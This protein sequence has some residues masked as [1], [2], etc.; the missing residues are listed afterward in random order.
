MREK[1]K[2]IRDFI[3]KYKNS[4]FVR[5][6][7]IIFVIVM[8]LLTGIN[9]M[10]VFS[11]SKIGIAQNE[12]HN[13][14]M[15]STLKN[16]MENIMNNTDEIAYTLMMDSEVE[17]FTAMDWSE[18]DNKFKY[19][20]E[21][22]IKK[23]IGNYKNL[24]EYVKNII[25]FSGVNNQ[26]MAYSSVDEEIT[27]YYKNILKNKNAEFEQKKISD[28]YITVYYPINDNSFILIQLDKGVISRNLSISEE[29]G[30]EFYVVEKDG[31]VA[32]E[33]CNEECP[34]NIKSVEQK[35]KKIFKEKSGVNEWEYLYVYTNEQMVTDEISVMIIVFFMISLIISTGIAYFVAMKMYKPIL[36]IMNIFENP[37]GDARMNYLHKNKMFGEFEFIAENIINTFSTYDNIKDELEEKINQLNKHQMT[38]LQS[39]INPHFLF[40]TLEVINL[41]AM[42]LEGKNNEV[43]EMISDLSK[44]LRIGLESKE[45]LF[46][47]RNEIEYVKV[48]IGIMKL[49]YY[50]KFDV[51]INVENE[52]LNCKI[53][54]IVLQP[55]VENS[56][57][58]GIKTKSGTGTIDI[59]GR[60]NNELIEIEVSDN[61]LGMSDEHLLEVTDYMNS[62]EIVETESIGLQNVNRRIKLVFGEEYGLSIY[63]NESGGIGVKITI[64]YVK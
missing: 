35:N 12:N 20:N 24:N 27:E 13:N 4:I 11:Y 34:E 51:N 52:I 58:H 9:I 45:Q 54:K 46:T 49:R 62:E 57:S 59:T 47:I 25:I 22:Y 28:E 60:K 3:R 61:G 17:M 55:L 42:M 10:M 48:Y 16:N 18:F 63:K 53:C 40:N 19:N 15:F 43:S 26:T 14:I 21:Q 31:T 37:N 30:Y 8:I 50:N 64:P 29:S 38:V 56:I 41:K 33:I 2:K 7:I 36:N 6:F 32:L 23:C 1:N 5:E 39:Q 44:L